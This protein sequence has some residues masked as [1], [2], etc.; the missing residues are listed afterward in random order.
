MISAI[1]ARLSYANVIAT[2]A[3]FVAL[4]G[5]AYAVKA[6][7]KG[8]VT[9]KSIKKNAVT[10]KKIADAA[11]TLPKIADGAVTLPKLGSTVLT[12]AIKITEVIG[13][14][15][16]VP[17]S[18]ARQ[19][20]VTCPAGAQAIAGEVAAINPTDPQSDMGL[21]SSHR[22]PANPQQW[23]I[24]MGNEDDFPRSFQLGAICISGVG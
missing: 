16:T 18:E 15:I 13:P 3:L 19:D 6:V 7:P 24:R 5:A 14:S 23:L 12:D 2:L 10:T 4:S 17:D 21:I 22:V 8:S 20:I 11:V 1:R 9:T